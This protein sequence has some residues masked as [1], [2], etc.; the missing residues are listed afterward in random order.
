MDC[1]KLYN[2]NTLLRVEKS[3]FQ[4]YIGTVFCVAPTCTND[5]LLMTDDPEELQLMLDIAF[6]YSGMENYL[7]QPVKSVIMVTEQS[8]RAAS[9]VDRE[10]NLG[11]VPMWN[12]RHIWVFCVVQ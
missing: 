1:Y 12:Q 11:D 9:K 5:V 3:G 6:D 2:D 4:A 8:K 10:W 7:L